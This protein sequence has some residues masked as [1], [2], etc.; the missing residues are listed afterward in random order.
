M[1]AGGT[2]MARGDVVGIGGGG[3]LV[4]YWPSLVQERWLLSLCRRPADGG[5]PRVLFLGTAG[6]DGD[7]GQAAFYRAFS[8]LGARC[9]ALRF[10]PYDMR[11]DYA[12]AVRAADL[13]YV[14]GGNTVGMVA[15]WR[16]FGFDAALREAW[17]AGTVLAGISAGANCWFE[18]YVTDS[19]PGGG[20]RAG[21]GF[22]PGTFCPHLDSET[23]RRPVLAQAPGEAAYGAGEGVLMRF[24]G[25]GRLVEAVSDRQ[26]GEAMVRGAP[27]TAPAPA[28]VRRLA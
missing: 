19:V 26:A 2:A 5:A 3:F 25:A 17:E 11:R 10:F 21:L 4:E 23:W 13:V 20:V 6:G 24:D 1:S 22:L 7:R 9:D 12:A 8:E 15:V 18:H 16:E 14:G 28:A 27:G